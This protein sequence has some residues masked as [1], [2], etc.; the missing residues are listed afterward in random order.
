MNDM[1]NNYKKRH[2]RYHLEQALLTTMDKQFLQELINEKKEE[3]QNLRNNLKVKMQKLMLK[4]YY[5]FLPETSR[6]LLQRI[7]FEYEG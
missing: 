1:E 2:N 5:E 4:P 6:Y 7:I 3:S